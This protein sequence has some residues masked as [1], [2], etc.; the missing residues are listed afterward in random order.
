MPLL[1]GGIVAWFGSVANIPEGWALCDGNNE[2]PDLRDKFVIG[3]GGIHTVDATG[4]SPNAIVVVHNHTVS[5][6][7]SSVNPPSHTHRF[8]SQQAG[9]SGA[10]FRQRQAAFQLNSS[11]SNSGGAHGHGLTLN[12][13]GEDGTNKNLPPYYALAFIKQIT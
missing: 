10:S 1:L 13:V 12:T 4:G 9:G 6:S 8:I 3:A 2:T 5:G 7:S 11:A